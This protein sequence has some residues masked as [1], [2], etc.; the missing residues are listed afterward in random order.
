MVNWDFEIIIDF[1]CFGI[2]SLDFCE[3]WASKHDLV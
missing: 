3:F 2:K 1:T